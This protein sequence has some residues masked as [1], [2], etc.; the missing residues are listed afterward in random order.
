MRRPLILS[1][2]SE[3]ASS[4]AVRLHMPG[5][6]GAE[7]FKKYFPLAGEDITELSFSGCLSSCEGLTFEAEKNIA[8]ILGARRSFM[9]TDGSS[10]GILAMCY[11]LSRLGKK[12]VIPRNSHKSVYNGLKLFNLEP[13]FLQTELVDGLPVQ[14]VDRLEELFIKEDD[15]AGVIL[16]SPDYYGQVPDLKKAREI[17]QKYGAALAIDGAHGG[18]MKVSCAECY[19]GNYAD[20]WVDGAHK[21]LPSLTQAAILN[22]NKSELCDL[23]VEGLDLFRTTSP[24]YPIMASVEYGVYFIE[25]K[26]ENYKR[27]FEQVEGLK[28]SLTGYTFDEVADA[29]KLVLDCYPSGAECKELCD[30]L[31]DKGIYCEFSD[32]RRIV[33]MLSLMT[34]LNDLNRLRSALD[35]YEQRAKK[36]AVY[37]RNT[38]YNDILSSRAMP[39][40]QASSSPFEW[41]ELSFAVG[42]I[43]AEN[44]GIFPPCYPLVTAGEL[45][46]KEIAEALKNA[47]NSFGIKNGAIK[48]VKEDER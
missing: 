17:T 48:V 2:L 12:V 9:L 34:S 1:A 26:E 18:H 6:K 15:I 41:E 36:H 33:F 24:S 35:E 14:R 7:E 16:T 11:A 38:A 43:A 21:T 8:E 45:V 46:T 22:V 39:Y 5:H 27:L 32:G 40:R 23:A 28:S 44:A 37:V 20:V 42:R 19:A 30:F 31:E 13:L 47:E 10:C 3:Y 4:S 29:C 25:G